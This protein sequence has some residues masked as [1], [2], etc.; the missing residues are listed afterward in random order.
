ME[1][2]AVEEDAAKGD[3][4]EGLVGCVCRDIDHRSRLFSASTMCQTVLSVILS[5]CTVILLPASR[6]N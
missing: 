6:R 2:D 5:R 1:G 4:V 3:A